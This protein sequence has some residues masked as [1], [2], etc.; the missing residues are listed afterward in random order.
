MT[1][2]SKHWG[3]KRG[4][5]KKFSVHHRK[6]SSTLSLYQNKTLK[7]HLKDSRDVCFMNLNLVTKDRSLMA[8]SC[9]AV[10]F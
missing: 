6:P 7:C 3:V 1:A 9:L 5:R 10:C 4:E 8:E 2:N